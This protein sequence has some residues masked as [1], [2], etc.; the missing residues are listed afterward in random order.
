MTTLYETLRPQAAMSSGGSGALPA[1][2]VNDQ[3]WNNSPDYFP[4]IYLKGA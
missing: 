3:G 2:V 1:T 4:H